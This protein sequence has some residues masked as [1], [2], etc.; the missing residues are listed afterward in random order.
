MKRIFILIFVLN[1]HSGFA[2]KDNVGELVR[3]KYNH[4]GLITDLG[5]GLWAWPFPVDYDHDGDLDLLV[6]CPDHPFN[7]IWFF[8]NKT[9]GKSPVFTP[10][11]KLAQSQ[12]NMQIS[13]T[14]G[15]YKV[16]LPGVAFPRFFETFFDEPDTLFNESFYES[17]VKKP[18]F[19]LWRYVD[20]ENDGDLDIVIAIDDWQDY[21]W[22]NAFNAKGEWTNGPLHG[23]IYWIEQTGSD[24][25]AAPKPVT[26]GGKKIDTY[27]IT[28]ANFNDF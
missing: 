28:G 13:N 9:G 3:I 21:G 27:G 7:G 24:K 6:N 17:I 22:D 14:N 11:V 16:M 2:Q 19:N 5:V 1:F 25:Y 18:R 4:P 20:Y 15:K 23:T 8:E 12:R 26:A 10:P